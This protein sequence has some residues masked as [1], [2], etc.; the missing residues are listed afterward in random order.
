MVVCIYCRGGAGRRRGC[1]IVPPADDAAVDLMRVAPA[2]RKPSR[3]A[4]GRTDRLRMPVDLSR[5]AEA[6]A[7]GGPGRFGPNSSAFVSAGPPARRSTKTSTLSQTIPGRMNRIGR[8]ALQA[9]RGRVDAA[10][11]CRLPFAPLEA[12]A[13]LE[14]GCPAEPVALRRTMSKT[15]FRQRHLPGR[16]LAGVSAFDRRETASGD[17]PGTRRTDYRPGRPVLPGRRFWRFSSAESS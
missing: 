16:R 2:R 15:S 13:P 10:R 17:E 8:D 9:F 14:T 12:D 7:T 6:G 4:F 3:F 1:A 11:A 5:F